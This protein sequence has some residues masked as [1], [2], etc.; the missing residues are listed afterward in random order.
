MPNLNFR[1]TCLLRTRN[2]KEFLL[3]VECTCVRPS[4]KIQLTHV[5]TD[6]TQQEDA[7]QWLQVKYL[8]AQSLRTNKRKHQSKK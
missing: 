8:A 7:N 2:I 3:H 6:H 5:G 4:K 1:K